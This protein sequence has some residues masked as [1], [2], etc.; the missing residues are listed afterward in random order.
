MD[1]LDP[2]KKRAHKIRLFTGYAL[3]GTALLLAATLLTLAATGYGIKGTSGEVTRNGLLFVDVHPQQATMFI[4][5]KDRGKTD[6]RFVLE[7]GFY[8]LELQRDG[9]R[10]W[11]R[12]FTLDGGNIVRL[13]YPFMFPTTLDNRDLVPFTSTPDMV[14]ESPD[15]RWI[16]MHDQASADRLRLV[17]TSTKEL[18][19]TEINFPAAVLGDHPGTQTMELV[20][21]STDNRR[22]LVKNTYPGGYDFIVLDHQEPQNSY[23]VTQVFG[24]PFTNVQLRD[25]KFDKLYLHDAS[26]GRLL[27]ADVGNKTT[28]VVLTGVQAFRPY[29]N[30]TVLY[31]T[32]TDAA[33]EKSLLR[34]KD[35]AVTY[36]IRELERSDS[37]LLNMAEFDGDT[38]VIGGATSDGKVYIYKNP[39]ES[40][41]KSSTTELIPKT[42]LRLDNPEYLSFSSNARFASIQSGNMFSVYDLE[43]L[44]HYKYDTKIGV[45]RG[46][47]ANWMDGHRL[48][49]VGSDNTLVIFD[50]DGL[51]PQS[52]VT[53]S[54]RYVP[55]F[56]RDYNQ[57]FTVGPLKADVTKQGLIRT[58]LNL[59]QE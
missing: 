35:D 43:T 31:T 12:D 23:N 25:K 30:D 20:E 51:N 41:K 54:G 22:L 10:P 7:S 15:R 4:N 6:G 59:G 8:N 28:E 55:L 52:L 50:Y 58:D 39:V 17:D 11:K 16:V 47:E 21:W 53:T 32:V 19:T 33:A 36:T 46:V 26:T 2:K 18:V 5:G 44:Q 34:L 56:D 45:T 13:V 27:T 9:Y 42:L 57:L 48:M 38:Y 37:Y 1:F 14:T 3:M 24:A 49:L 40:L 29:K